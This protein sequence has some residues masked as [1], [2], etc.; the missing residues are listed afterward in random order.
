MMRRKWYGTGFFMFILTMCILLSF[1]STAWGHPLHLVSSRMEV[2]EREIDVEMW[3]NRE[4]LGQAGLVAKETG[5]LTEKEKQVVFQYIQRGFVAQ[6]DG[7]PMT[8]AP[9]GIVEAGGGHL[10]ISFSFV[11][12]KPLGEVKMDYR[13]FFTET[14]GRHQ[15]AATVVQGGKKSAFLL[16]SSL[17]TLAF[18]AGGGLS[19]WATVKSFI[20]LGMEHIW[21]GFDHQAFLLALLLGGGR[22]VQL[23][24]TV[25]AFTV[26]HSI[27]LILAMFGYFAA[28]SVWVESLI[29][30]SI[31]Y[32]ALENWRK[33]GPSRRWTTAFFFGLIHG[34]GFAGALAE[35]ALPED[36]FL[37]AILS[38][39]L[40]VEL[41][42][43]VIV[44]AVWPVLLWISRQA[45]NVRFVRMASAAVA[46]LGMIWLV[47]RLLGN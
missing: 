41:G 31:V 23:L 20:I 4:L 28:P 13:I 45:W 9:G 34:L 16:T 25:T 42:Q 22:L 47:E 39:N 29:A 37:P 46:G 3:V 33:N 36:A 2:K 7:R 26:A 14:G 44:A 1:T 11:S 8:F 27:T 12:E 18:S 21:L 10:K 30:F 35:T 40:G 6:N 38:F 15:H 17:R 24:K 32:A 5:P 43:L 19:A